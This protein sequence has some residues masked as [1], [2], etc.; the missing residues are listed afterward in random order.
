M[1]WRRAAPAALFTILVLAVWADPLFTGRNFTGRD[2]LVY[3]L[4]MEKVIHDAYASG[5]LPVWNPWVSGG[6]PLL[7]NPNS[8]ALYPIRMLMSV[9]PF[10]LAMRLYPVLHWIAAGVGVLLLLG[11]LGSGG[12]G[13]WL[14]AATYVFSG[15][16]V[17]EVFYPHIQPGFTLLP[18]ILWMLVRSPRGRF[19]TPILGLLFGL[20]FLAGDVF[21]GALAV[22]ACLLW[23]ATE[24]PREEGWK[25]LAS[26]GG[27]V[28]LGSLLAAPQIVATALWIP[29]TNRA[30]IGMKLSDVTLFSVH[31]ARLLEFVIPYPFGPTWQL[32]PVIWCS[33]V[34]NGKT[35]G[36]FS[37]LFVGAIA[38]MAVVRLRRG[39][40][41]GVRFARWFGGLGLVV[42]ILPSLIP[43][44]W[45][46]WT[47]PLPLRNPE[48]LVIAVVLALAILSA[49]ALEDFRAR[50]LRL[51]LALAP[52]A[53][54]AA[55]ALVSSIWRAQ[56][57]RWAATDIAGVPVHVH[58]ASAAIPDA[59]AEAGLLWMATV[60]AIEGWRSSRKGVALASL[61]LLTLVPISAARKLVEVSHPMDA[62]GPTPFALRLQKWDPR[63][64]YRVLGEAIYHVQRPDELPPM[65]LAI[66]ETPRRDWIRH[67]HAMWSRGTVFNTDFDSG[68]LA[69][70]ESLRRLSLFAAGYRD[71]EPFF[72]NLSLKWGIRDAT[73]EPVSAYRRFGGDSRQD[74]DEIR[75]AYP[76]VRLATRW[77]ERRGALDALAD[78]SKLGAGELLL[79]TGRAGV[80]AARAGSIRV[81]EKSANRLKL[82]V[83]APDPTWLFVLRAFWRFREVEVDGES[84]EVVP[85]YLAFSAVRIPTGVH[86]V[87]WREEV[88]GFDVSRWGPAFFLL[89]VAWCLRPRRPAA[90]NPPSRADV[91]T[92]NP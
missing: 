76:D 8:G 11:S 40:L 58:F 74:W 33:R 59:L 53:L 68:D 38:P 9:F 69:R 85:A 41:P 16:S 12:G 23:I 83:R 28:A 48:K 61:L 46:D 29:E 25:R 56:V 37:T 54:F 32:R 36:L 62:F 75:N 30:V 22:G 86:R 7:P 49:R 39:G 72:G 26:L 60:V 91:A 71:S 65:E 66:A 47:S 44:A 63:N 3:N 2:L 81:L 19:G 78:L 70:V 87:D 15:A 10:D 17:S 88:P 24:V 34:F 64:D 67:T 1:S 92:G 13:A 57:G 79:E 55:A 50:P 31:P 4:P 51:W 90:G 77:K 27:A 84:A 42:S 14:G 89:G 73:Q 45:K 18:W 6:R 82:E 52:G 35:L 80:G 21:T 5:S 20:D 43:A